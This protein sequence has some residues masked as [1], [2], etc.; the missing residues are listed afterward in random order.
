MRVRAG[1]LRIRPLPLSGGVRG[2]GVLESF[3]WGFSCFRE[4]PFSDGRCGAL[5]VGPA[6][7]RPPPPALWGL[8]GSFAE[9]VSGPLCQDALRQSTSLCPGPLAIQAFF[10]GLLGE[11]G[12]TYTEIGG[13][14]MFA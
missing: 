14:S 7:D 13:V 8:M 6:E 11:D 2:T 12:A 5:L 10:Y 3:F 4:V 9:L 1:G